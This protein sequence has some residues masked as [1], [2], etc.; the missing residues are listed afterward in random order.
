[1]KKFFLFLLLTSFYIFSVEP[2]RP[3]KNDRIVFAG[4]SITHQCA[5]TQYAENFLYTRYHDLKLS[6]F[7]SGIKGNR[8]QAL[9][10]RWEYDLAFRKP[11]FVSVLL[12]MNDGR[13]QAFNAE[14]FETYKKNMGQILDRIKALNAKT[15]ILS[16]TMFDQ[17]QY[18]NQ[19]DKPDFRFK[20]L[21]AHPDYNAKLGMYGGWLRSVANDKRLNFVDFWGPMNEITAQARSLKQD[22]TLS[23][24]SIHPDP[25]GMAIMAIQLADYFKGERQEIP[26]VEILVDGKHSSNVSSAI[27]TADSVVCTVTPKYLPWV[28]YGHGKAGPAPWKYI[29]DP[30]VGFHMGMAGKFFNDEVIRIIG[31]NSGHYDILMNDKVILK[32]VSNKDLAIGIKI[33][34]NSKSVT[35]QQSLVLAKLN[36]KRND[37]AMRIYRDNVSAMRRTKGQRTPGFGKTVVHNLEHQLQ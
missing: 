27:V 14:N 8:A 21:N 25:S 30:S 17:Q 6:T 9:L 29:D 35:H 5:Y 11:A 7:N 22:F 23:P 4:D 3:S 16:P 2:F 32:S 37:E 20:R 19:F 28:L 26:P 13:Y 24:D 18:R 1:M 31:L 15:I 34:N 33:Q 10:D 12:G 36:A